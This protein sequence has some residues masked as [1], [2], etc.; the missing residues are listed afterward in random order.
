MLAVSWSDATASVATALS[1][2]VRRQR[3]VQLLQVRLYGRHLGLV[4]VGAVENGDLLALEH[5][6]LLEVGQHEGVERRIR[7]AP[8]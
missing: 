4:R 1:S 5:A 8:D 2:A 7:R 6:P 3:D